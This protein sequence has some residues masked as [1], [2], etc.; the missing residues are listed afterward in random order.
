MDE[1][2]E[3]EDGMVG[4]EFIFRSVL[5]RQHLCRMMAGT[6]PLYCVSVHDGHLGSL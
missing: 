4:Q 5:G 3:D 6:S 2:M 1:M